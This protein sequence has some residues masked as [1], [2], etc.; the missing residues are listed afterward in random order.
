MLFEEK[1]LT[2]VVLPIELTI[3]DVRMSKVV[4]VSCHY[5]D[6]AWFYFL[7]QSH[8]QSTYTNKKRR[9]KKSEDDSKNLK[10]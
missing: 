3:Q 10:M 5:R 4:S 2:I 8:L 1:S 6:L 7:T 9:I